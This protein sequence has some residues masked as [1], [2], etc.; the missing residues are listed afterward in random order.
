[1]TE[2]SATRVAVYLDF[3]NIVISRYD[4]VNGRNSY[5]RDKVKGLDD[6]QDRLTRATVEQVHRE[7]L[8]RHRLDV[9]ADGIITWQKASA[10]SQIAHLV[11]LPEQ[12]AAE[13]ELVPAVRAAL[14]GERYVSPNVGSP[15]G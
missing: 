2:S 8:E 6:D 11:G 10:L 12:V 5:Q 3:D 14:R 15:P 13:A 4:Q 9:H 1:M 7:L